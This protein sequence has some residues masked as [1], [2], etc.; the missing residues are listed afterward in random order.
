MYLSRALVDSKLI[1]LGSWA[2]NEQEIKK[3]SLVWRS[4]T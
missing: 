2:I 1:N 3:S 4:I